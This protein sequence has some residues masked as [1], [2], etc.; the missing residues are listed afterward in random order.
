MDEQRQNIL[1]GVMGANRSGKSTVVK[2]WAKAWRESRPSSHQIISFDPQKR[3][4]DISDKFI[5]PE[6]AEWAQRVLQ[7]KNILLILDDY[8]IINPLYTPIKGL[9]ELMIARAD[10]NIDIIY[11]C[12]NPSLVIELLTYFTD[13]YYIFYTNSKEGSFQKKIPNYPLCIAAANKV[14]S[15]VQNISESDYEKLYPNFPYC[16]VDVKRK[17]I[18]AINMVRD[19]RKTKI[20]NKK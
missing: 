9:S 5:S 13:R 8:R 15:H 18:A 20:L 16:V 7:Y 12:H 10:R 19:L 11:I 1:W 2:N 3:F 4:Q 6:D 17:S 14:N